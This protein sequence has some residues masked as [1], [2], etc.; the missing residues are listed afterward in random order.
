[1]PGARRAMR[2]SSAGATHV[3]SGARA[4]S[5]VEMMLSLLS[6]VL[7]RS[8]I[9]ASQWSVSSAP[10]SARGI[11]ATRWPAR[12]AV[13]SGAVGMGVGGWEFFL[14]P[15]APNTK[16]QAPITKY[17]VFKRLLTGRNLSQRESTVH[18]NHLSGDV[19]RRVAAQKQ[20]HARDVFGLGHATEDRLMLGALQYFT[21]QLRQQFRLHESGSNGV[22]IDTG[23]AEIHS[24]RLR[25]PD[26]RRFARRIVCDPESGPEGLMACDVHDFSK[27]LR[28]HVW[29]DRVNTVE[30]AAHVRVHDFGPR[31]RREPPESAVVSDTGVVDEIVHAAEVSADLADEMFDQLHLPHVAQRR[32]TRHAVGFDRGLRKQRLRADLPSRHLDVVEGDAATVLREFQR[33]RPAEAGRAAGHDNDSS[34]DRLGGSLRLVSFLNCRRRRFAPPPA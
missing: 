31:F 15:H 12:P 33:D 25:E 19:S 32:V 29:R 30:R 21:R 8:A 11:R 4:A 34:F 17:L 2:R 20:D 14:P 27:P 24:R 13:G 3:T 23:R 5:S 28:P 26:E 1:M 10:T 6:S 22:H 16:P 9:R 7:R 18:Y